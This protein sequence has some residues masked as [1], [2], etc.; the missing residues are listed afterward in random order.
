LVLVVLV[1][2]EGLTLLVTVLRAPMVVKA[3]LVQHILLGV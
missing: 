2:L 3:D 1:V